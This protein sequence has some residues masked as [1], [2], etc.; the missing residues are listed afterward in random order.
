MRNTLGDKLILQCNEK[1]IYWENIVSFHKFQETEGLKAG[2]KLTKQH[3]MY[4]NNKMNVKLV[5]QTLNK[6][7]SIVLTFASQCYP[8]QFNLP[9]ETA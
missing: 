6:C 3:I 7:V 5:V 4:K 1:N 8:L 9:K 2:T